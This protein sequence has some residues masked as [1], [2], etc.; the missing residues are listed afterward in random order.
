MCP[1]ITEISNEQAFQEETAKREEAVRK[2]SRAYSEFGALHELKIEPESGL[3][4][5]LE[6]YN[7]E[8][9]RFLM[10]ESAPL[11]DGVQ[12]TSPTGYQS[13]TFDQQ[14]KFQ[15]QNGQMIEFIGEDKQ[16]K[17]FLLGNNG[18]L[19]WN[20]SNGKPS[21]ADLAMLARAFVAQH[22]KDAEAIISGP[23]SNNK[24]GFF[25]KKD[26][27]AERAAKL[28][29]YIKEFQGHPDASPDKKEGVSVGEAMQTAPGATH[30]GS[31]PTPAES[32]TPGMGIGS[33]S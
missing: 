19:V 11:S 3:N 7:K 13:A 21:D 25:N 33:S 27:G 26:E 24:T 28:Q 30:I 17:S 22:G 20:H 14:R 16:K 4:K 31:P 12:A 9:A 15:G 8:V 5:H 32:P 2:T 6:D 10:S 18:S 23:L 1:T 29:A